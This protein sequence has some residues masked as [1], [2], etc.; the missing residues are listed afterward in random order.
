MHE[1]NMSKLS[2]CQT[3]IAVGEGASRGVITCLFTLI[4][5]I[6]ARKKAKSFAGLQ[7]DY[8]FAVADAAER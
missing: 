1:R 3:R 2:R 6:N 8:K 4:F 5:V 7:I